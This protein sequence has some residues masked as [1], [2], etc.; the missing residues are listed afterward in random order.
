MIYK[1]IILFFH[2]NDPI[3]ETLYCDAQVTCQA[4]AQSCEVVI[5]TACPMTLDECLESQVMSKTSG[6]TLDMLGCSPNAKNGVVDNA[7]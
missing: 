2:L 6:K 3:A 7:K 1:A 5:A 4:E